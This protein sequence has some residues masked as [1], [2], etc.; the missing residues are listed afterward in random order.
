MRAAVLGTP[1]AHSLS[2]VIHRAGYVVAGPTGWE[3]TAYEVDAAGLPW[4]RLGPGRDLARSL[5][6]DAA[7]GR[8]RGTATTVDAVAHSGRAR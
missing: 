1:I 5:P 7:Q 8:R 4:F 3:Y 2:L 6:D